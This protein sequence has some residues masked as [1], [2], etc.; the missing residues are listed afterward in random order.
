VEHHENFVTRDVA[1]FRSVRPQLPK[2]ATEKRCSKIA[3]AS[4]VL[5][6]M[7]VIAR[8]VASNE[9]ENCSTLVH[10]TAVIGAGEETVRW[11]CRL[12]VTVV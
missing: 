6:T 1:W 8:E 11:L 10:T 12:D 9:H 5:D 3:E 2:I 7:Q 4:P